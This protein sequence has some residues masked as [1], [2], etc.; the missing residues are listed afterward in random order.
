MNQKKKKPP[1]Y[2]EEDGFGDVTKE[3]GEIWKRQKHRVSALVAKSLLRCLKA[4]TRIQL[5]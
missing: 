2:N 3:G 4:K 5:S 1:K